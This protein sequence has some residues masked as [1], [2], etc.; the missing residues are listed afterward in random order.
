MVIRRNR[1]IQKKLLKELR[2]LVKD[3]NEIKEEL[4]VIV[5]DGDVDEHF[6]L[7]RDKKLHR[8]DQ[9]DIRDYR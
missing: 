3:T 5:Y 1:K 4:Q 6:I 9:R 8:I 7:G 2:F